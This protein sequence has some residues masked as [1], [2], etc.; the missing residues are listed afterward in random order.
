MHMMKRHSLLCHALQ[1]PAA[2]DP[3]EPPPGAWLATLTQQGLVKMTTWTTGMTSSRSRTARSQRAAA[4]PLLL[5]LLL[6]RQ[7]KRPLVMT[8]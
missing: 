7:P 4:Q 8:V 1:V 6:L 2:R 3:A 5:L